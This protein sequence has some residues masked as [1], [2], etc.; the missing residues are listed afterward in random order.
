M[1]VQEFRPLID[2]AAKRHGLD[3]K[4]VAAQIQIE[5]G[6][7]PYAF[8]PERYPYVWDLRAGKPFRRLDPSEV[9]SL[10]APVDF[11]GLDGL[12]EQEWTLQ[13]ASIGLGQLMG[14]VARELGFT[15]TFL[16]E[17]TNP[18]TNIEFHCRKLTTDLKWSGGD[19]R[20]ALAAYNGG[21][22]GNAPG[23]LLRN[24]AYVQKVEKA[25]KRI[26]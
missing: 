1:S 23:A 11:Y 3:P 21:R 12:H 22:G 10:L 5:S 7:N 24:E 20:S 19:I 15:G 16:L 6:G 17:L 25:M 9:R 18:E 14:A 13:R 4:V 8:R 26:A 2:D